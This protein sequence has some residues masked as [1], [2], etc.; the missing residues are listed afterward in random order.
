MGVIFPN[1]GTNPVTGEQVIEEENVPK[2]LSTMTMAGLYD[3]SGEWAWMGLPARSGVGG[4]IL[5]IV[6]RRRHD[7]HLFI[8]AGNNYGAAAKDHWLLL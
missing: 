2:F 3:D 1:N 6:P 4:G 5:A 7:R 8:S